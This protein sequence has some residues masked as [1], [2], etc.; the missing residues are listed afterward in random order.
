MQYSV[1]VCFT[2]QLGQQFG[3][4]CFCLL[5]APS[6]NLQMACGLVHR[7]VP[8]NCFSCHRFQ[9]QRSWPSRVLA[10][11]EI[12]MVPRYLAASMVANGSLT[13]Q[14]ATS[15]KCCQKWKVHMWSQSKLCSEQDFLSAIRC[16][17]SVADRASP[18]QS[19]QLFNDSNTTC[20]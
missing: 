6:L 4:A 10:C 1:V 12:G 19:Q 16:L 17:R 8:A 14:F 3:L 20:W 18:A 9:F 2:K 5:L 7:L 13:V 15:K 11:I